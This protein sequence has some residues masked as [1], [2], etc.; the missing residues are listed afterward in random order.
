M[1][2][3]FVRIFWA[4]LATHSV[5]IVNTVW[6]KPFDI[7]HFYERVFVEFSLQN[8]EELTKSGILEKYGVKLHNASL[9]PLPDLEKRNQEVIQNLD[10]LMSYKRSE[11]SKTQ[12]LSTEILKRELESY[13]ISYSYAS[14][15]YPV[16]H[17]NG[18]HLSFPE[19]MIANHQIQTIYD[20][21][22]Y[23]DRLMDSGKKMQQVFKN[24]ETNQETG[25]IPPSYIA[26]NICQ[27]IKRFETPD[28]RNNILYLDFVNKVK[29]TEMI[30]KKN[31]SELFFDARSILSDIVYPH[32]DSLNMYFEKIAQTGGQD[33]GVWRF[34]DGEGYYT[35]QLR[36]YTNTDEIFAEDLSERANREVSRIEK[37]MRKI[38]TQLGYSEELEI[39]KI[40]QQILANPSFRYQNSPTGVDSCLSDLRY[41]YQKAQ[42][43][44]GKYLTQPKTSLKISRLPIYK[45]NYAPLF[46]YKPVSL[47]SEKSAQFQV[48][49]REASN[50][51]KFLLPAMVAEELIPGKHLQLSI[52]R[53]IDR[54]TF[55][56]TIQFQAYTDGWATYAL[57]LADEHQFFKD[58]YHQ[59][60][61]WQ[62]ELLKAVALQ[63]DNGIHY[64]QWT[65][66]YAVEF[67]QQKTGIDTNEA[68][69][70]VDEVVVYPAKAWAY[71]VG[72]E[73]IRLAKQR[74]LKKVGKKFTVRKFHQIILEEGAMPIDLLAQRI[75]FRS[76]PF[77][78]G[79]N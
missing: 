38:T 74:F 35:T 61:R 55:R 27:Q 39:G 69:R 6:Y 21:R 33:I 20:A 28:V 14:Y 48:N 36:F 45:E 58:P 66:E 67:V 34:E 44:V 16:N 76:A 3:I 11:Q 23:L 64:K 24:L 77:N 47:G 10:M 70:I 72:L 25:K 49:L 63:V 53:E 9:T 32:Y 79:R 41:F 19:F 8:P 71:L 40:M 57:Y 26:Q 78:R 54:P 4:V 43:E 51:H 62:L 1:K 15:D 52:Q 30:P 37:N 7:E 56:K 12:L 73:K 59:L 68:T 31:H 2:K 17:I 18:I 13:I 75:D 60:G 50:F 5:W 65:K 42:K 22:Q 29:K 46:A